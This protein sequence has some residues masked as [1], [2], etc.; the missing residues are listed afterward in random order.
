MTFVVA[1]LLLKKQFKVV[2]NKHRQLF[3]GCIK[4]CGFGKKYAIWN[5]KVYY[6][7]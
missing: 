5:K 3:N 6:K 4:D 7:K 1:F 2:K